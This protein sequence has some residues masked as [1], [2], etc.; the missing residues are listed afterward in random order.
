VCVC[1]CVCK[2]FDRCQFQEVLCC[3]VASIL[4][5]TNECSLNAGGKYC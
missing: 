3:T 1:V 5:E 4:E 2:F